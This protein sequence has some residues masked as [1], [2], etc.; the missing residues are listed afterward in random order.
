[1]RRAIV[2]LALALAACGSSSKPAA[3][4]APTQAAATATPTATSAKVAIDPQDQAA[5][6]A[7]Y[8]RLRR[9]TTALGSA[10]ELITTALDEKQLAKQ[11]AT[12]RQ[13]LERSA[14]L[15]DAAVVPRPLAEA[16]RQLVSSLRQ[17]AR[18]FE[19][20]EQ[21]ARNG[22]FQGAAQA[23]TDRDAIDDIIASATKI[24]DTCSS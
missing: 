17:Y 23:M 2:L 14:D 21:P 9:V 5:C 3:T 19:K 24:E 4:P 18:G 13:Q 20:A 10:S 22:D 7:L 8:G 16:N 15:M 11:I 12:E 6:Q 1:M